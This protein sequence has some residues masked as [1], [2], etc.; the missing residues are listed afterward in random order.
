[1]R[2]V[3]NGSAQKINA[4][5]ASTLTSRSKPRVFFA[6]RSTKFRDKTIVSIGVVA[7]CNPNRSRGL[8]NEI[9]DGW[10]GRMQHHIE[11][12]PEVAGLLSEPPRMTGLDDS[13]IFFPTTPDVSLL[14]FKRSRAAR[15]SCRVK[16]ETCSIVSFHR[17]R[18]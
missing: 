6:R 2:V 4:Y 15:I 1:M 11:I 16:L 12:S 7:S 17:R 3:F 8:A 18:H 14:I 5:F 9:V 10:V 13:A